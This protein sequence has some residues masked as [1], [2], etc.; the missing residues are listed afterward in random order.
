MHNDNEGASLQMAKMHLY[1]FS[2]SDNILFI[3][4]YLLNN[5]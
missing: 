3:V 5:N 1:F 2:N 4:K